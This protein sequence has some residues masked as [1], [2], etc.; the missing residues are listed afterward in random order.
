M[1]G[2]C[3]HLILI[4][5]N[6]DQ[7]PTFLSTAQEIEQLWNEYEEGTSSAAQLVKDFDKVIPFASNQL[8]TVLQRKAKPKP[9]TS[10]FDSY[11]LLTLD[12]QS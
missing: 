11:Y 2:L 8:F 7:L 12:S 6:Q 5:G 3:S 9:T 1:F 10:S 4:C